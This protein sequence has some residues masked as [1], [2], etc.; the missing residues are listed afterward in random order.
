MISLGFFRSY[1]FFKFSFISLTLNVLI[2]CLAGKIL[3]L[4]LAL[5]DG[6]NFR[7]RANEAFASLYLLT[8]RSNPQVTCN[9][10]ITFTYS[11]CPESITQ[12]VTSTIR[13]TQTWW[14]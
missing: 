5:P 13:R 3:K 8:K 12:T 14:T 2:T 4:I 7:I 9:A 11:R 6:D 10:I 1:K